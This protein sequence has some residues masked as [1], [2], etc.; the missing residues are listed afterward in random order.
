MQN[1]AA[2]VRRFFKRSAVVMAAAW[3]FSAPTGFAAEPEPPDSAQVPFTQIQPVIQLSRTELAKTPS[4]RLSKAIVT[5]ASPRLT[6]LFV[7]DN[8]GGIYVHA[9]SPP[10]GLKPGDVVELEGSAEEGRFTPIITNPTIKVLG[11]TKLPVPDRACIEEIL[12]GAMDSQWVV[13][14]GVVR[15]VQTTGNLAWVVMSFGTPKLEVMVLDGSSKPPANWVGAHVLVK[16]VPGGRFDE[17]GRM[18]GF[19]LY[20]SSF[21]EFHVEDPPPADVFTVPSSVTTEFS[22]YLPPGKLKGMTRIHGIVT[23]AIRGQGYYLRDKEGR[24]LVRHESADLPSPGDVVDVAGFA[25]SVNAEVC[26][27]QAALR[28]VGKQSPPRPAFPLIPDLIAGKFNRELVRVEGNVRAVEQGRVN[29]TALMIEVG[30]YPLRVSF[31]NEPP[32]SALRELE[33]GAQ[34]AVTGIAVTQHASEASGQYVL[35]RASDIDDVSLLRKAP[36]LASPANQVA[37]VASGGALTALG[38][39]YLALRMRVSRQTRKI[40][41]RE[42]QLQER[43]LEL[44]DN[45]SDIVYRHDLDGRITEINRAAE[46]MFRCSREQ[47]IGRNIFDLLSSDDREMALARMREKQGGRQ[48]TFYEVTVRTADGRDLSFEVNSRVYLMDGKPAGVEGI[49]RDITARK[50]DERALRDQ[51]RRLRDLLAA[52]EQLGRD[53]HDGII[54]SIYAVGLSLDECRTTLPAAPEEAKGKIKQCVHSLNGV[55]REVRRFIGGLESEVLTAPEVR[56]AFKSLSLLMNEPG[57]CQFAVHVAP[58]IAEELTEHQAKQLLYIAREA[59]SNCL[60][61][62]KASSAMVSLTMHAGVIRLEVAD[63]GMGFEPS[64]VEGS[65]HGLGNMESRVHEMGGV[66]ELRSQPGRGTTVVVELRPQP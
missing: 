58:G 35:I 20:A 66:F 48:R 31:W 57:T 10:H 4:V 64:Q 61:H 53:L 44:Y 9:P 23:V 46:Q 47:A 25:E 40:A 42:R 22:D 38:G 11:H 26:L 1:E 21:K 52:R 14:E 30:G 63:D 28:Q 36:W 33:P 16:G 39:I 6:M 19:V 3:H 65:G 41:D 45:S 24:L 51:E 27:R 50:H 2:F 49:A 7:Q 54:Q 32:G 37:T 62:A 60:R 18:T 17:R 12:T 8:T 34:V 15:S 29:P 59:M 5:I 13:C 56:T 55:I 43:F